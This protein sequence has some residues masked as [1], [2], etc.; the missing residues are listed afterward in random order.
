MTDAAVRA[1]DAPARRPAPTP[2]RRAGLLIATAAGVLGAV[3][4]LLRHAAFHTEGYDLGLNYQLVQSYARFQTPHADVAGAHLNLLGDHFSPVMALLAPLYW[5]WPDPRALLL[6]QAALMALS[7]LPVHAMAARRLG[8]RAGALVAVGYAVSWPLQNMLAFDVHEVMFA[9]PLIALA[10]DALD[11][12]RD[13]V[14]LL[15][16]AGLLVVKEDMGPLVVMLGVVRLVLD[17]RHATPAGRRAG[18]RAGLAA[19]GLGLLG[20]VVAAMVVIPALSVGGG[21]THWSYDSLGPDM[22]R[23]LLSVVT[24]PLHAVQ[25]FS[26]PWVKQGS[27]DLLLAP[28]LLLCL[29]SP[30]LLAVLPLL[31]ERFFSSQPE[32]WEPIYHYSATAWPIVVLAGV[33]GARRML[34]RWPRMGDTLGFGLLG[35]LVVGICIVPVIFPMWAMANG[36]L[37]RD[38]R[39][40]QPQREVVARIPAGTCVEAANNLIPHLV[41]TNRVSELGQLDRAPDFVA[42]DLSAGRS[43]AVRATPQRT[44]DRVR[45][46]GYEEVAREGDLVLYRSPDYR[47]PSAACR[48]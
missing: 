15:C 13:R 39:H 37:L 2:R 35:S 38:V 45:S 29:R 48:P 11:R 33:D 44:R 41:T 3:F 16:C 20:Y 42:I 40:A 14:F 22:P 5:I 12:R 21:L 26:T 27:L 46:L 36:G 25:L 17:V 1:T 19:I 24:H 18:R 34:S 7:V 30:M 6:A 47:G 31:A 9:V 32:L 28:T 4:A 10:L 8:G 43:Q 23:A